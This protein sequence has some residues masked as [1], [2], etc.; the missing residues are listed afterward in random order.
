MIRGHKPSAYFV[1]YDGD[2]NK[3]E[4]EQEQCCHCQYTW[5]PQPGS[6]I[7]RGYCLRCDAHLCGR[8]ECEIQQK[9][10]LAQFSHLHGSTDRHCI[11]FTDVVE[12]QR[13]AYDHDPRYK[14]LP[15]GIVVLN[16]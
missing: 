3:I 4:G 1:T 10:L 16:G 11:P 2:G 6:G 9:R 15:S 7:R 14:V 13:D 8:D 12:R 5:T